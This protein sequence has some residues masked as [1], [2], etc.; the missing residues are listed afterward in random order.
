MKKFAKEQEKKKGP[1]SNF[2]GGSTPPIVGKKVHIRT[3]FKEK[4]TTIF[5][6]RLHR[7]LRHRTLH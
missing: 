1:S 4:N 7:K 3:T 2:T 6:K 5:S